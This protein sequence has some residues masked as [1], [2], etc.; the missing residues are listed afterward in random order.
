VTYEDALAA[1]RTVRESLRGDRRVV[2]IGVT[3][4]GEG[5]AVLVSGDFAEADSANLIHEVAGVPVRFRFAGRAEAYGQ[6]APRH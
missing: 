5:F 6:P 2:S 4:E 1:K 3:R